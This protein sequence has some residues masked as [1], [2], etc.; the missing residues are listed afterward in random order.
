MV[1]FDTSLMVD[2]S[3]KRKYALDLIATYSEKEQIATTIITKYEMLRGAPEQY[4]NL[5]SDV[6]KRFVILDFGNDALDETVKVYK[7]L[8]RK[9][10]LIN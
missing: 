3:R 4:V 6:L 8:R 1:V 7:D 9:G 10:K 2:A 5:I